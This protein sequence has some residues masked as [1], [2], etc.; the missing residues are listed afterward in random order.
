MNNNFLIEIFYSTKRYGQTAIGEVQFRSGF[1]VSIESAMIP[2][3]SYR[4]FCGE[5]EVC[6]F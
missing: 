5:A 4:S 2:K 1:V 6:D 3:T